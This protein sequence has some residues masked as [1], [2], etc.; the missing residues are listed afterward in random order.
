MLKFNPKHTVKPIKTCI[1][2]KHYFRPWL[3]DAKH[4][5]CSLFGRIS[6]VNSE[7]VYDYAEIV[8]EYENQCGIDALLHESNI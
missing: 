8:R 6:P 3:A 1:T 2:C 7:K 5:R 4:G